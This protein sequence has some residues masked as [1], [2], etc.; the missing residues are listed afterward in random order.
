[1][2]TSVCTQNGIKKRGKENGQFEVMRKRLSLYVGD[3]G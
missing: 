3:M 2:Q 1:M